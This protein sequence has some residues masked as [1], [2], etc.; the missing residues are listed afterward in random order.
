MRAVYS[1]QGS[2]PSSQ[3]RPICFIYYALPASCA[4]RVAPSRTDLAYLDDE[5]G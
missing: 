5:W 1:P 2:R 3:S 4:T